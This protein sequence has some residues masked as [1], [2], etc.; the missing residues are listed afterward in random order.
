MNVTRLLAL[1]N[2][3]IRNITLFASIVFVMVFSANILLN[4]N[5]LTGADKQAHKV[6]NIVKAILYVKNTRYHVVQVQQFL[7]DV[8][9]TAD[10]GGFEEAQQNMKNAF[11][12]LDELAMAKP[13]IKKQIGKIKDRIKKVHNVGVE[14]AQAYIDQGRDAGNLIMKRPGSGL[15]DASAE[16]STDLEA[17]NDSINLALDAEMEGLKYALEHSLKLSHIFG[18]GMLVLLL[19]G[20]FITYHKIVPPLHELA[21]SL[22]DVADGSRDLTVKLDE[23]GNDEISVVAQNF[24]K[25]VDQIHGLVKSVA[26]TSLNLVTASVEMSEVA[27]QTR[28]GMGELKNDTSEVDN[29]L[30]RISS[31]LQAMHENAEQASNSARE[32]DSEAKAGSLVVQDNQHSINTLAGLVEDAATVIHQLEDDSKNIGSILDVIRGIAEQT[33]LLALN[34]AIEAARAGEQ[35]RGFAVVADEVRTLAGRTQQSTTEIQQMIERLQSGAGKAVAAM[36]NGQNQAKESVGLAGKA[37][38]ALQRILTSVETISQMNA[39]IVSAVEQQATETKA[40]DDK[41]NRIN[42]VAEKTGANAE[43]TE[44]NS[45]RVGQ[46]MSQ[47]SDLVKEFHLEDSGLD[48]SLAK[49]KHLSWKTRVRG[50][51]D[52]KSTLTE[53]EAVSHHD[54]DFGKWYYSEGLKEYGHLSALRAVEDPHAALHAAIREVIRHK[55]TGNDSAAEESYA[56]IENCSHKV[57]ELL[58]QA[59]AQA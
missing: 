47:L 42:E 43:A 24:N 23:S 17:L 36:E 19:M 32:A 33:N 13:E 18:V 10:P 59:E 27:N 2:I 6:E 44:S 49:T 51:L 35:G 52:G 12:N 8:G 58:G 21:M 46:M 11:S 15:D 26:D 1:R 50:Y 14:M 16:L 25:F 29:A 53:K 7:T 34:A 57:V 5:Q 54:C 41:M 22:H 30:T 9:A 48:F 31:S 55:E 38:E 40:V 39:Q 37:G 4:H 20:V 45:S 56:K 3:S 28:M